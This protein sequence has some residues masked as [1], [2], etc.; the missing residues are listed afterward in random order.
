MSAMP[1]ARL[2]WASPPMIIQAI[3]WPASNFS[4]SGNAVLLNWAA[5]AMRLPVN[6]SATSLPAAHPRHLAPS[7]R[8]YSWRA[9]GRSFLLPSGLRDRS[10]R[11]ALPAFDKQI[12]GFAMHDAVLTASRLAP[13][14]PSASR[15]TT[16]AKASIPWDSIRPAKVRDMRVASFPRRWMASKWRKRWL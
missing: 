9:Y 6:W 2:W 4:D 7:C 10:N 8:L 16:I 1:T 11:E 15:E 5:Q 14:H 12:K 13:P 3:H